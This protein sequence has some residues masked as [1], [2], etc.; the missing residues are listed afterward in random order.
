M[1]CKPAPTRKVHQQDDAALA[2]SLRATAS[3]GFVVIH[4]ANDE[5]S[6]VR[7]LSVTDP[8]AA[9]VLVEPR[10]P[11]LIYEVDHWGRLVIRTDAGA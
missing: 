8:T 4:A 10:T 9:P 3:G 1:T 6:E 7:L 2:V 5:Q 11:G